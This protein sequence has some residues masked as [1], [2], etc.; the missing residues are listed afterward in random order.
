MTLGWRVSVH[1]QSNDRSAPS[2]DGDPKGPRV[3]IWRAHVS[4]L[5]W[6]KDLAESDDAVHV[7]DNSGYPVRYTVRA[8]ALVP[9][10]LDGPPNV[11]TT[12][13]VAKPSDIVGFD[14]LPGGA[15]ID[16][17]AIEKCQP[18]EWL[19]VEAWDES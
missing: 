4:G 15:V 11:R 5:S 19:Q 7:A 12:K 9:I 3:A 18:D 1:R 14:H 2:A 16:R 6:L 17:R 10:I 8:G 13:F